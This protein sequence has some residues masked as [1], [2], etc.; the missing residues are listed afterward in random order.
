MVEKSL[1][2]RPNHT[3]IHI[4]FNVKVTKLVRINFAIGSYR[5]VVDCDIVPMDACNILLGRPWQFDTDCMHHGR[6]N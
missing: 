4:T 1:H 5:D 2:L 3:H 6:S